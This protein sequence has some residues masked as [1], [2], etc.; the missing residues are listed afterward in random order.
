MLLWENNGEEL[1][2]DKLWV[3]CLILSNPSIFKPSP[4]YRNWKNRAVGMIWEPLEPFWKVARACPLVARSCFPFSAFPTVNFVLAQ[5]CVFATHG[6]VLFFFRCFR[7]QKL[8][9]VHARS[10]HGKHTAEFF[11]CTRA[12]VS[13]TR[14]CRKISSWHMV[15]RLMCMVMHL[16]ICPCTS[17]AWSCAFYTWPCASCAWSCAFFKQIWIAIKYNTIVRSDYTR[18][19][20][21]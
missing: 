16:Y 13:I 3:F 19:C 18:S 21:R 17:C 14:A 7:F 6:R 4:I 12:C 10:A 15:M 5:A 2:N 1:E 20:I 8:A 9:R 11:L